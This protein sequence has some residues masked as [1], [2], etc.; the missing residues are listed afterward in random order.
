MK[1]TKL[2]EWLPFPKLL[3]LAAF[4]FVLAATTNAHVIFQRL[5]SF[6]LVAPTASLLSASDGNLYGTTAGG[7]NSG[8]G[9]VFQITTDGAF[10][11]LYSFTGGND[12]ADPEAGLVQASDGKLYGTTQIDGAS[13]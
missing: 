1:T 2:D 6:G 10:T 13:G 5:H 7:G 4:C 8:N 11:L 12:G 9:T 3:A